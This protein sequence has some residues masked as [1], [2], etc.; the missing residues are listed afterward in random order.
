MLH[1][2]KYYIQQTCCKCV[3]WENTKL[4]S[5]KSGTSQGCILLILIQ[6]NVEV[7]ERAVRQEN[8]IKRRQIEKEVKL[9]LHAV[10]D[11]VGERSPGV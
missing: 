2:N 4:F 1:H 3:R 9:P 7:L 11:P 6:Y 10:Y 8:D 5:L